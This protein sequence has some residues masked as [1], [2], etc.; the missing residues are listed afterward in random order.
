[1]VALNCVEKCIQNPSRVPGCSH[2]ARRL[3]RTAPSDIAGPRM[4][5]LPGASCTTSSSAMLSTIP[6]DA[7]S[8]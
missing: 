8:R 3:A 2:E 7:A 6:S 1:M 4:T 5:R